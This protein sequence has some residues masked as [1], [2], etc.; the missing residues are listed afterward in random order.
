M[1]TQMEIKGLE[2][3]QAKLAMYPVYHAK[4]VSEAVGTALLVLHEGVPPYPPKPTGSTYRRTHH[5]DRSLGTIGDDHNIYS[6]R[7][8]GTGYQGRF[9]TNLKYAQY[10]IGPRGVQRPPFTAYWWRLESVAGKQ[11]SKVLRVFQALADKITA[12][13][14][15]RVSP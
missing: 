12:F 14:S 3:L 4:M 15:S 11:Y 1:Q 8:V 10:V 2:E 5:L 13:L 7:R 6:I 9:G